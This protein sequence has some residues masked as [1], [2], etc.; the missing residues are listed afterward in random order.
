MKE[1]NPNLKA[2][3]YSKVFKK[4]VSL[5]RPVIKNYDKKFKK[6]DEQRLAFA[7]EKHKYLVLKF[8]EKAEIPFDNNQAERDLRM[9]KVKQKVSGCFRAKTQASYFACIRG[10]I[11]TLKKNKENVLEN[12][13][14]AFLKNPFIPVGAE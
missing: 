12:I 4:Y 8:I 13:Q 14:N 11:T 2:S 3:Y 1:K 10:Y 5:I 7:L 9:I 6:T